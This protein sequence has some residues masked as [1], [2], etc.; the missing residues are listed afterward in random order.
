[1]SDNQLVRFQ[2]F[3]VIKGRADDIMQAEGETRLGHLAWLVR[4]LAD[5]CSQ[6]TAEPDTSSDTPTASER[7]PA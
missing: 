5:L 4:E 7:N 6:R 2:A 3:E 1:M